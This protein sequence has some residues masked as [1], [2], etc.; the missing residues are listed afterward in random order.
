MMD[1]GLS[2]GGGVGF[3]VVLGDYP[4]NFVGYASFGGNIGDFCGESSC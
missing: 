2:C 4:D 1:K 3:F